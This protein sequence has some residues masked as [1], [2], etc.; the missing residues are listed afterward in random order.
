[1]FSFK[2]KGPEMPPA[3]HFREKQEDWGII[4]VSKESRQDKNEVDYTIFWEKQHKE[5]DWLLK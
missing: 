2:G 3:V 1:M 4:Q 5:I